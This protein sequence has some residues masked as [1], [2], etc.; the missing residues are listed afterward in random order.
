MSEYWKSAKVEPIEPVSTFAIKRINVT[1]AAFGVNA[2][3]LHCGSHK[4]EVVLD[5]E[6]DDARALHGALRDWID[7]LEPSD[8]DT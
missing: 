3:Y 6:L 1:V 5:L 4:L 8:A 2:E 7:T